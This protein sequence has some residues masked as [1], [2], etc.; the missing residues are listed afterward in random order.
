[1]DIE[2]P[3][4]IPIDRIDLLAVGFSALRTLGAPGGDSSK[5]ARPARPTPAD[6]EA[7]TGTRV[8]TRIA[9]VKQWIIRLDHLRSS[10]S[11]AQAERQRYEALYARVF[12]MF[13]KVAAGVTLEP[14]DIDPKTEEITVTTRDG[15]IPLEALSQG[16]LSLIAWVGSL[17]Q[18]L[19]ETASATVDPMTSPAI[20]L[21]DEIDAHMHPAWQQMLINRLSDIFPNVQ[22]L[23]TS[24][25]PLLVGSLEPSQVYRFERNAK[26]AVE[27]S[28]PSY[29][30]KGLGAAGLL[31]SGLFG[32]ASQLDVE[33]AADLDR[34]RQLTSKVLN[35]TI[36]AAEHD[37]LQNLQ[38]RLDTVDFTTVVR[39]PLYNEFVRAMV[40]T[41]SAQRAAVPPAIPTP[42]ERKQ[43]AELAQEIAREIRAKS[44]GSK[45]SPAAG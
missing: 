9:A 26:G 33:T 22:F 18:R 20:V 1:V 16:T 21:V 17:M 15:R 40:D 14:G 29:R 25:S 12:Q 31:T 42:A 34:K 28:T 35:R 44:I 41:G 6:L 39:D 11:V 7:L 27:V 3:S 45:D 24:H 36:T 8:D 23:A 2:S 43:T 10:E 30:L 4:G 19:F 13:A 38:A 5:A 32:L 37:E